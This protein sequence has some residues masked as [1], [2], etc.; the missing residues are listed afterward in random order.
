MAKTQDQKKATNDLVK[1]IERLQGMT[2]GLAEVQLRARPEEKK[3]SI[4]EIVAHL[5]AFEPVFLSR[6]K[7]LLTKDDP[8]FE[9]YDTDAWNASDHIEE[10]F[11]KNLEKFITARKKTVEFLKRLKD[12]EWLR[13]GKHPTFPSYTIQVAA[14]KVAEH[15]RNHL[16]QIEILKQRFGS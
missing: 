11:D 12:K 9:N 7:T 16:G 6:L 14:E 13:A 1:T 15:D 4:K 5:A 2:D 3:W 8:T 10:D